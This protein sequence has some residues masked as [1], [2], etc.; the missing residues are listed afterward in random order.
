M[1]K[2]QKE[3]ILNYLAD[4]ECE[5]YYFRDKANSD[6]YEEVRLELRKIMEKFHKM[7]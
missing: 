2:E 6:D 4:A 1:N 5:L 7:D 3:K